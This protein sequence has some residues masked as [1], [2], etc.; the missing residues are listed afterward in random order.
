[1]ESRETERAHCIGMTSLFLLSFK[2][3]MAYLE[4]RNRRCNIQVYSLLEDAK[5]DAPVH[6][7]EC[8]KKHVAT[9]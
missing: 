1:M 5:R 4:D 7:I 9:D 8:I 6:Y 3:K 2:Q